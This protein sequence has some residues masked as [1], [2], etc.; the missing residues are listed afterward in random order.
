ME[1]RENIVV[2]RVDDTQLEKYLNDNLRLL[3]N[4]FPAASYSVY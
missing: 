4:M 1:I 3:V 2:C